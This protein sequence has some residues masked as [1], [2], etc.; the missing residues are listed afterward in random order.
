MQRLGLAISSLV[1]LKRQI[2]RLELDTSHF[3]SHPKM[4][5]GTDEQLR[6]LVRESG[7]LSEV[8]VKL[9]LELRAAHFAKLKRRLEVLGIDTSRFARGRG[10]HGKRPTRWSNEDLRSA[11]AT[12]MSVAQTI[13]K[14]ELIPAGGNYDQVQ[15]RIRELELDTSHFTGAGWNV[16]MAYQPA[17][18]TPLEQVLVAGRPTG[19]HS[20]KK[21]LF[22]AGLK[23]PQCELCR[24]AE[25]A[26]EGRI[27]V[28]LDHITGDRDD[29]RLVNLRILCPNCHSLQPTHRGLNQR[30]AKS[31][32]AS[33][34]L[35]FFW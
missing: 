16:G 10:K 5:P 3:D 4:A 32:R 34:N 23:T 30:R 25:R 18:A 15:K 8:L 7:T 21:R 24:W 9:G 12:S 28:E 17:P 13:R 1:Y 31:A 27:P 6:E 29:N 20:L 11:V 19:S 35:L 14:L 22:A 33:E 26:P 2:A